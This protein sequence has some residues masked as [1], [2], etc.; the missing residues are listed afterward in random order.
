MFKYRNKIL[1]KLYILCIT[2][3]YN[4]NVKNCMTKVNLLITFKIND[5]KN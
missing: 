5:Q 3:V 2:Y 4:L 1:Y